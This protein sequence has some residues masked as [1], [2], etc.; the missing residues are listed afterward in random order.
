MPAHRQEV[1][2]R[3]RDDTRRFG[4]QIEFLVFFLVVKSHLHFLRFWDA[5]LRSASQV[6]RVNSTAMV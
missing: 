5:D 2:G 1:H 6:M 4:R 3:H